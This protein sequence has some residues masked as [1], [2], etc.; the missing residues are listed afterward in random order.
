MSNYP[1]AIV[2]PGQLAPVPRRIRATLGGRTVL[3]TTSAQYVWEIPPFPQYYI[4]VADVAGGVLADTGDTRPSDLGV[5]RVHTAGAG[6]A[7]LYDDGPLAGL[8]RFEWDALD[9]W[10]EED[11]E[12]FV[13]PRNPYS[14]CDALKSG[15]RVRVCLD[16]VVLADSTSTVIVFE[17][18][19]S[20]RHYFPRTA[21]AFDHLEPS[22]TETACPYKGRTSAYW[23]IRTDTLHPDLAWSYDF[24]TAALLP[25]AGHVAFFTE[26]L[27]LTV[28]GVP[29]ARPVT[30]FSN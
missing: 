27:D 14:R 2:P 18:G 13:H 7:W 20:P 23:S 21:V 12:V 25:I 22:D 3:D 17:T 29:V 11:E 26:K 8:V 19:L 16:D 28:D 5:G 1:E 24:P 4:P 30:P 15:R 6:R 9:S 10:F